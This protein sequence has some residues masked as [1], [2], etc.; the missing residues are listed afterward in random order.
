MINKYGKMFSL[1]D[2]QIQELLSFVDN[3]GKMDVNK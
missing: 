1:Y 3:D 2:L